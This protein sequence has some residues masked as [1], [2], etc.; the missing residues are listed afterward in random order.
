[1]AFSSVPREALLCTNGQVST[2]GIRGGQEGID[3]ATCSS[4]NLLLA[5]HFQKAKQIIEEHL[6]AISAEPA[7]DPER[8]SALLVF[9]TRLGQDGRNER[10]E[11]LVVGERQKGPQ[12]FPQIP[13]VSAYAGSAHQILSAAIIG[14]QIAGAPTAY[15]LVV[16]HV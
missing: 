6:D 10:S 16:A 1:M 14:G 13:S 4:P 15:E 11:R 7:Q 3:E 9:D 2:S 8:E 12:E 5:V